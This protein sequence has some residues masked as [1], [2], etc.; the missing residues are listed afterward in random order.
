MSWRKVHVIFEWAVPGELTSQSDNK[1]R[2]YKQSKKTL[3]SGYLHQVTY[4]KIRFFC[5]AEE[6]NIIMSVIREI[7]IY[8][9]EWD[10]IV[11]NKSS[12]SGVKLN[13]RFG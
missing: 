2:E 3:H 1:M 6:L 8:L 12:K 11:M 13:G 7:F 10:I 9:Y 4:V 5:S